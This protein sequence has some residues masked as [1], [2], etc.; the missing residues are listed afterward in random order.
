[1]ELLGS[2]VDRSRGKESLDLDGVD[3]GWC[4]WVIVE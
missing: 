4:H 1:M 2:E 3:I